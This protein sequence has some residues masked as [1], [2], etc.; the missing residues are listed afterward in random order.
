MS[1][2]DDALLSDREVCRTI[3]DQLDESLCV[4]SNCNAYLDSPVMR[5]RDQALQSQMLRLRC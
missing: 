1:Q 2:D 3:F 4:A 5:H